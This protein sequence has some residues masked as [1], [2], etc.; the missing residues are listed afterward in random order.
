MHA[1]FLA[2]DAF[3][4]DDSRASRGAASS[5]GQSLGNEPLTS[6]LASLL[7]ARAEGLDQEDVELG[8]LIG[9]GCA[10][11][12]LSLGPPTLHAMRLQS[13]GRPST[14]R[15]CLLPLL[16]RPSCSPDPRA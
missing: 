11:P 4:N 14:A 5:M 2:Q 12:F 16:R 10:R 8:P 13:R 7:R 3:F 1:R 6:N 15:Q 9:R